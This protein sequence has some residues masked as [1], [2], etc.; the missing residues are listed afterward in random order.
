M[1]ELRLN[2][3]R[4]E[5]VGGEKDGAKASV[6]DM[7]AVPLLMLIEPNGRLTV[8]GILPLEEAIKA[9]R[10]AAN[11]MQQDAERGRPHGDFDPNA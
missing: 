4:G 2:L 1:E 11:Q 6:I 7:E 9:M 10:W 8:R 3:D 5:I